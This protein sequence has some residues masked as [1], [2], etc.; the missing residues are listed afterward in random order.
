[1]SLYRH[2]DVKELKNGNSYFFLHINELAIQFDMSPWET[3]SSEKK[4]AHWITTTI[5]TSWATFMYRHAR[6]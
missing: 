6:L 3:S 4:W 1:M 5:F 2:S